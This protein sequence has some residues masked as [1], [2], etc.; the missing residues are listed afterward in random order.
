MLIGSLE[1]VSCHRS[2]RL[3]DSFHLVLECCQNFTSRCTFCNGKWLKIFIKLDL[4]RAGC[5]ALFVFLMSRDCCVALRRNVM[6]LSA[7][8]DCVIS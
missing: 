5:F 8:C 3:T 2:V 7:V 4:E 1:N 6:S